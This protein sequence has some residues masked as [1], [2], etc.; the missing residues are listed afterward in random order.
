M[1]ERNEDDGGRIRKIATDYKR[2]GCSTVKSFTSKRVRTP[3]A[4]TE[5]KER[6]KENSQIWNEQKE[7]RFTSF[8]R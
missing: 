5:N 2:T 4:T 6:R 7:V 1:D 3:E 8:S